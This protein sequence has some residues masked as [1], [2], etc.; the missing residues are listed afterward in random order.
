M[1]SEI[2]IRDSAKVRET[3]NNKTPLGDIKNGNEIH[4]I[5]FSLLQEF[6]ILKNIEG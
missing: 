5:L 6:N 1:L 3:V 2:I 4:E